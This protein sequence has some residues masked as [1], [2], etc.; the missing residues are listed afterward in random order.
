MYT[1]FKLLPYHGVVMIHLTQECDRKSSDISR[2]NYD[3]RKKVYIKRTQT[4]SLLFHKFTYLLAV[5]ENTL[6]LNIVSV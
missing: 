2:T 4:E 3:L 1:N 5:A 6:H